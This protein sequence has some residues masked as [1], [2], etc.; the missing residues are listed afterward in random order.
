MDNKKKF[1]AQL[2]IGRPN[3]YKTQK[4]LFNR[5][6]SQLGP[7]NNQDNFVLAVTFWQNH[8]LSP[9]TIKALIGLSARWIKFQ[10]GPDINTK[11]LVSKV[12]RSQ[13]RKPVKALSKEQAHKLLGACKNDED[14]YTAVLI[15]YHTG[16]RKG[17]VWGLE[18][19]DIDILNSRITVQRSFDGPTKNGETRHVPISK[20]LETHLLN[21]I[22]QRVEILEKN[23]HNL[24]GTKVISRKF[25]PNP[26]LQA[27]CRKKGLPVITFH[28]LRHTFATLALEA[29]RSP[30]IVQEVLGHT[31][32]STTLDLYW[33]LT[34]EELELGF[35]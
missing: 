20:E 31:K 28:G 33:S 23:S 15:A 16:M 25:D 6:V 21:K 11:P 24:I 19:D 5:W 29:G 27:R 22:V 8:Q 30:R 34:R 35:C 4:S 13:Q 12:M 32:L 7:G 9:N 17:E 10:G 14:L 26:G 18:W 1:L 3:T 2:K